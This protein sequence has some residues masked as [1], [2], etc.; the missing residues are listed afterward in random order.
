M[1]LV[2]AIVQDEDADAAIRSLTGSGF[3]VTRLATTGG[4]LRKGNATL[5][6]GADASRVP[7]AVRLLRATC[8]E[9][10]ELFMPSAVE[11]FPMG[12]ALAPFEVQVGGATI[13]VLNVRQFLRV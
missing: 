1:R 10:E 3:R 5:L 9:R 13:F 2:V 4:F 12:M 11:A 8:R 6:M 7:E